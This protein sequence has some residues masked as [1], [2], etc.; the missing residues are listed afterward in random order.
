MLEF[1]STIWN[2]IATL[3]PCAGE[4]EILFTPTLLIMLLQ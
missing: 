4:G 3:Q 1:S 2:T